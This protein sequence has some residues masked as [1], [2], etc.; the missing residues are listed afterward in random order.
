MYMEHLWHNSISDEQIEPLIY[1]LD[2]K[3][4]YGCE[5]YGAQSTIVPAP[6]TERCFLTMSQALSQFKGSCI[7]G[8]TGVGKTETCKVRSA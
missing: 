4:Q 1:I 2:T 3:Y 6:V 7:S 5:F 8:G